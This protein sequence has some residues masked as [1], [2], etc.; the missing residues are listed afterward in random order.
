M[1]CN[2]ID[3]EEFYNEWSGHKITHLEVLL[4]G[5]Q[6]YK[7]VYLAGDSSVDNKHWILNKRVPRL[8]LFENILKEDYMRPDVAYNLNKILEE[9]KSDYVCI[10]SAIEA[11]LLRER[12]I[13]LLPQDIV[14]R[15][16]IKEDDIL[17]I[18][19]GGNDIALNPTNETISN[20][21]VLLILPRN[22]IVQS[23]AFAYFVT[24]FKNT[25]EEYIKKLTQKVIPKRI[26]VAK[27]YYPCEIV[28]Q[29]WANR[30]LELIGYNKNSE[31][32]QHIISLLYEHATSKIQIQRSI[33]YPMAFFKSLNSKSERDYVQRVEPS[34]EGGKKITD[35]FYKLLF[36]KE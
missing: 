19:V 26:V 2:Q 3:N 17:F 18:S 29:S 12:S 7:K 25:I 23:K 4:K 6:R 22:D 13:N 1:N 32:L 34:D 30:F 14:I 11:T 28:T 20:L 5:F 8:K 33:L 15:D 24:L 35:Y 10:N 31:V 36:N 27:I 21:M 16:N 9:S